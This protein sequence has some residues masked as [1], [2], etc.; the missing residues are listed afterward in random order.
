MP[1][2]LLLA[3]TRSYD[4]A[5]VASGDSRSD[6]RVDGGI[7]EFGRNRLGPACSDLRESR[8]ADGGEQSPSALPDL[9]EYLTAEYSG[10]GGG[11]VSGIPEEE[12]IVPA[13]RLY[14]DRAGAR[15][16][17]DLRERRICCGGALLGGLA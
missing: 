12:K 7:P 6:W 16:A 1:G 13:L 9:G 15:G 14:A 8:S 4:S 2:D 17:R 10:E 11:F 5:D 3:A